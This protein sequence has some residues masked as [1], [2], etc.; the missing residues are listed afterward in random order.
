MFTDLNVT[1][2]PTL[3]PACRMSLKSKGSV[4]GGPNLVRRN[5]ERLMIHAAPYDSET[6]EHMYVPEKGSRSGDGEDGNGARLA[7]RCGV[8]PLITILGSDDDNEEDLDE[9]GDSFPRFLA[10][11]WPPNKDTIEVEE[12]WGAWWATSLNPTGGDVRGGGTAVLGCGAVTGEVER[13]G[14]INMDNGL[15]GVDSS[16]RC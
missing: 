5:F 13:G 8:V 11:P 9:E 16:V 7:S 14:V 10:R 4:Q 6:S 12:R 3:H 2:L 1:L 15:W